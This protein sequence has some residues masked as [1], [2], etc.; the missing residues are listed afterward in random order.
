MDW[1]ILIENRISIG[2]QV[3]FAFYKA[4]EEYPENAFHLHLGLIAIIFIYE[5]TNE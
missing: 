5:K 3:G 2:F 1:T 4:N